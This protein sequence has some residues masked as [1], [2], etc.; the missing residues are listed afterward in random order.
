MFP[1]NG[2][3]LIVSTIEKV[4]DAVPEED[5]PPVYIQ[6]P[7]MKVA[8]TIMHE[9]GHS[10]GLGHGGVVVKSMP[11]TPIFF[12]RDR[13]SRAV[14]TWLVSDGD[15]VRK[16]Q[17]IAEVKWSGMNIDGTLIEDNVKVFV[18]AYRDYHKIEII[19]RDSKANILGKKICNLRTKKAYRHRGENY[20]PNH[21]SVMNYAYK[22]LS[23][24]Q[25]AV[26]RITYQPFSVNALSEARLNEKD[27]I[28]SPDGGEAK[29]HS[30]EG[31]NGTTFVVQAN[32][33]AEGNVIVSGNENPYK[34]KRKKIR[35]DKGVDW[36]NDKDYGIVRDLDLNEPGG[37]GVLEKTD[38]EW[39]ALRFRSLWIGKYDLD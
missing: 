30:T 15:I 9:L 13:A 20:K 29:I 34:F 17:P 39:S 25:R 38:N 4:I 8:G 5:Q 27:G 22:K 28:V 26:W 1:G 32:R 6:R 18:P 36:N 16:K 33:D 2:Q 3:C 7:A 35:L 23:F 24:N 21:F 19:S 11:P 12:R 14:I 31:F 10:M 37:V